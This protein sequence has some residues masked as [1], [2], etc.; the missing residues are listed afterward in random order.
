MFTTHES[1]GQ[2]VAAASLPKKL[3]GWGW[4]GCEVLG[5]EVDF[6]FVLFTHATWMPNVRIKTW[7]N[8]RNQK[9]TREAHKKH[10]NTC[11]STFGFGNIRQQHKS[12]ERTQ[13]K[14]I[15]KA[16]RTIT[17]RRA[18]CATSTF[19]FGS[20][21][22]QHKSEN[23]KN[24]LAASDSNTNHKKNYLQHQTKTQIRKTKKHCSGM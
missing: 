3:R 1:S 9:N 10:N 20:I 6:L 13:V 21:R 2:T 19:D 17:K 16:T 11:D 5:W 18:S 12:E 23:N 22:Q 7:D 8:K 15:K 24:R 14:R 4:R